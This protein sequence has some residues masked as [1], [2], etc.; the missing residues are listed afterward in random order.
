M[1]RYFPYALA[2]AVGA[3][4]CGG[5]SPS[6][7]ASQSTG[8][9][10]PATMPVGTTAPGATTQTSGF[11]ITISNMS[12]SPLALRAPAGATVTVENKDAIPHSVT[13]EAT[14]GSYTP[15]APNGLTPFDTG[16]FSSGQKTIT[17]PANASP[18]TVIPYYC[19]VHRQ[20]MNTPN[21]TITVDPNARP[22]ASATT[23]TT[24][25]STPS[26]SMPTMPTPGY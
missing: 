5:P 22:T 23:S 20:T 21:G 9:S 25:T 6:T 1:M 4:G 15:G 12:F 8:G 14:S 24:T 17:V 3:V 26:T 7:V 18:G 10:V 19:T 16:V 13:S 2:L 11:L